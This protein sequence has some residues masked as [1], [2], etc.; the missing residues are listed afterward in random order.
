MLQPFDY[1]PGL[2]FEWSLL[3]PKNRK[4]SIKENVPAIT[5]PSNGKTG[6][7]QNMLNTCLFLRHK[8][9]LLENSLISIRI[10]SGLADLKNPVVEVLHCHMS[11]QAPNMTDQNK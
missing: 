3:L 5:A 8:I 6:E 2:L 1:F 9:Q 11:D 4:N 7:L 10:R